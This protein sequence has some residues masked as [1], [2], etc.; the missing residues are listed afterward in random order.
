MARTLQYNITID[1]SGA[2]RSIDRVDG[3][4]DKL[5]SNASR[6]TSKM[7]K[8]FSGVGTALKAAGIGAAIGA[9]TAAG[10]GVVKSVNAFSDLQKELQ[11]V[12]TLVDTNK[13]SMES[14]KQGIM[15]LPPTLGTA[16]ENMKALYQA[17]SAGAEPA[18][19]IGLVEE[20]A[21]AAKA[22]LTDTF[23][24]VDAGTSILNAYGMK[25]SEMKTIMDQM[26]TT[27]K[28]GK[29]TF[30]ELASSVGGLTPIASAAGVSTEEM[31]ASVAAL[32][33]GG[34]ATSEAMTA[35][36]AAL[37]NIIK[38]SSQAA[39]LAEKLGISFDATTLK[40]KG[41][42]GFLDMIKEATGGNVEQMSQLFGS[43]E[44]LNAVLA[45][46]G[47]SSED[48]NNSLESMKNSA[49]ATDE[50]FTKQ[51]ASLS[52]AWETLK[53][54]LDKIAIQFGE[55]IV[56]YLM[57]FV[58]YISE[59]LAENDELIKQGIDKFAET[60]AKQFNYLKEV[61]TLFKPI[62]IL[63]WELFKK[64]VEVWSVAI[65]YV[66]KLT[67]KIN[68]FIT[69][70]KENDAVKFVMKFMGEG[71]TE[72]PL[73]EK[74]DEMTQKILGFKSTVDG[75]NPKIKV[76]FV[77]TSKKSGLGIGLSEGITT[78]TGEITNASDFDKI[79]KLKKEIMGKGEGNE[80]TEKAMKS[81]LSQGERTT[82]QY[83]EFLQDIKTNQDNIVAGLAD[84]LSGAF[85]EF[86]DGTKSAKDAFLSFASS[87]LKQ[88]AQMIIQAQ[89]FRMI[90]SASSGGGWIGTAITAISKV[91]SAAANANGNA[92]NNGRVMAF[93]N[94]G[95]VNS[96][97]VFPMAN[98]MGLMGEAG[99]EAVMP[100]TRGA[101]GKLGVAASGGGGNNF[102]INVNVDSKGRD[103]LQAAEEGRNIAE[104]LRNELKLMIAYEMKPGGQ[105]NRQPTY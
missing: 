95:I 104:Q 64:L 58:K 83:L 68:E 53:T 90:N 18:Q 100:L 67:S 37:S 41:L 55:K 52:A 48:F 63:V 60:L 19:A 98:G 61:F 25:S 73:S 28:E 24:A 103:K 13:V 45:L 21:K 66:T 27:V 46:T 11:N 85:L 75:L 42:A 38:P 10:A 72:K 97:T 88:I 82:E 70:I 54:I 23:T 20:A 26:F 94:G 30:E 77:V 79:I 87:F 6:H 74:I 96:P 43:V 80:F 9:V 99:P 89:I 32:T 93:A 2:I 29:T 35:M 91:G 56:P 102:N 16:T 69:K 50:A 17:I 65:E 5:S 39:E 86:I 84:G 81:L 33:K 40:T 12:S 71:S 105:F 101:N 8:A 36:K 3:E 34:V 76:S 15:D 31:F 62:L 59:W 14:L 7:S 78:T 57:E 92:Y 49:G 1:E 51:Q 22:G 4:L 44:A 47:A